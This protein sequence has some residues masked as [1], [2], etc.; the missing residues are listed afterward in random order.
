MLTLRKI[1]ENYSK[2]VIIFDQ[3]RVNIICNWSRFS[4]YN[5]NKTFAFFLRWV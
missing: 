4:F 5:T 2:Y 1:E 3:V